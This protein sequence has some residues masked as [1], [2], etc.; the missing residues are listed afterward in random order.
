[1][2]EPRP[3]ETRDLVAELARD[4]SPVERIARLRTAAARILGVWAL[5]TIA[6]LLGKGLTANLSDPEQMTSGFG[7]ILAGSALVGVGSR[8]AALAASVPGR[9]RTAWV[10][11]AFGL[12]GALIAVALGAFLLTG[13]PT[14][15]RPARWD[16]DM[17]CL[18][19]ACLVALLPAALLL[20]L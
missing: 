14:A 2:S 6:A 12:S 11:G 7:A 3:D 8:L 16:S 19:L 13:D 17:A 5:L 9:E 18:I 1:M 4:L 15:S 10:A 20:L